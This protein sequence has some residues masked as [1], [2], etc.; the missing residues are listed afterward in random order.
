ME[1]HM[2]VDVDHD[3]PITEIEILRLADRIVDGDRV[4]NLELKFQ[5]KMDRY[6]SNEKASAAIN[7]RFFDAKRLRHKVEAGLG[8]EIESA[9]YRQVLWRRPQTRH[10]DG[11]SLWDNLDDFSQDR[12]VAVPREKC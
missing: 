6:R 10:S 11:D 7:E 8:R 2:D 5:K 1:S 4:V 9:L 3:R 12:S